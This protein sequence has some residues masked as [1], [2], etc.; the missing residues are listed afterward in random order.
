MLETGATIPELSAPDQNGQKQSLKGLLGARGGVVYFYPKD[1][2]PGC[3]L[4]AND[5]QT[6]G[7]EFAAKGFAVVGISK[8]SVKSHANFCAKQGLAF[9]L[10]SDADGALCEAFGVW[11]EKVMCGKS[12]M[13]IVRSTFVVDAGGVI[14]TVY[15]NVKTKDHAAQVL[16]ELPAS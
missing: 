13:G 9:T 10:L 12:C 6:L 11:Q 16:A 7:G 15:T 2:T 8:D 5:F 1:S 3:T 14:R 4:E